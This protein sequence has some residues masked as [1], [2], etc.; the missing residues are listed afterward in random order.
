M[1]TFSLSAVL[2][3]PQ[4]SLTKFAESL[5]EMIN[6]HTVCYHHHVKP[7][8][9]SFVCLFSPLYSWVMTKLSWADGLEQLFNCQSFYLLLGWTAA[10][11]KTEEMGL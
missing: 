7:D 5:Q 4:S 6:Y 10:D 3:S 11:H 9:L 2:F 1:L 8:I